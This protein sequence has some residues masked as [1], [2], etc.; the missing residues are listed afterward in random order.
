MAGTKRSLG[1]QPLL[2]PEPVLLV[3]VYDDDNRPNVMTAAW[4]GICCSDPVSLMV[5]IRSSG[6]FT[7]EPLL[8][9]KAF[10]VGIAT[11][12]MVVEADFF[13]IASGRKFDKLAMTGFTAVKSQIV[14]APYIDECPVVLECSLSNHFELGVH[15]MMVG[16]I[17]D[18]K[19][20]EDCLAEGGAFPDIHKIAPL[21]FDAGSKGYFGIGKR[22][23][24]A[25]SDGKALIK[26]SK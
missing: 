4:G 25:F 22:V 7:Y 23:G 10:T 21:V 26:P 2:Y 1:A 16:E 19:A 20:D 6:R 13:G 8:R 9:R 14:D 5:G 3:C 24:T 11:E 17:R 15:T 18:V 12:K